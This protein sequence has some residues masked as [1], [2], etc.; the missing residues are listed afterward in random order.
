ME[1]VECGVQSGESASGSKLRRSA[2]YIVNVHP[3]G[4]LKLRRSGMDQDF[5]P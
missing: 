2:M 5:G 4:P 1:N 3:A